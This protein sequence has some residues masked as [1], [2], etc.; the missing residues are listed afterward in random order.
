MKDSDPVN[1]RRPNAKYNLSN[2]DSKVNPESGLIFHYSR[3]RR[4]A[5]APENVQNLYNEQKK[6]VFGLFGVLVAD[7]PRRILFFMII[8]LCAL[9]MVLST[10]GFFDDSQ[11]LD[12]NKVEITGTIYEGNTIIIIKKT[13]RN[14]NAYT[15]AVDAAVSPITREEGD[16]YQVF[17]HRIFFTMENEEQYRF[18]VPFDTP[19]LG[20]VLQSDKDVILQF[21]IKPE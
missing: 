10:L 7:R 6:T 1:E 4:L 13:V 12:G 11:M 5:K 15:G 14:N 17:T 2:Q 18:A 3:E 20:I 9:I 8:F 21:T 16:Q 19:E